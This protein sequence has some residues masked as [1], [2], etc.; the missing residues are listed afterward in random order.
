M[1]KNIKDVNIIMV[2]ISFYFAAYAISNDQ[3]PLNRLCKAQE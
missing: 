1:M 2:I 3:I